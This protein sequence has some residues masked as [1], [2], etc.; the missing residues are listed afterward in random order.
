M[1]RRS[2][3]RRMM[4]L[5]IGKRIDFSAEA[6]ITDGRESI[7]GAE[8]LGKSFGAF[9]T[10]GRFRGAEDFDPV[11]PEIIAEAADQ[12]RFRPHHD[13]LDC[14]RFAERRDLSVIADV[15]GYESCDFADS[16]IAGCAVKLTQERACRDCPGER[17]LTTARPDEK[18]IEACHGCFAG[19][20]CTLKNGNK[21]T[22]QQQS[23]HLLGTVHL[24]RS[25]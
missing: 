7:S 16:R 24:D 13:K 23:I 20:P 18:N 6:A 19:L 8:I 22:L 5:E 9:K 3:D 25:F 15:D 10:R 2:H 21:L 17:V 1:I 11:S 4:R 14:V 12:R